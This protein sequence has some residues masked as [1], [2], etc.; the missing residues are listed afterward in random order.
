MHRRTRL[1][2]FGQNV[3]DA[4]VPK[5]Q[6]GHLPLKRFQTCRAQNGSPL[7]TSFKPDPIIVEIDAKFKM[8]CGFL[9]ARHNDFRAGRAPSAAAADVPPNAQPARRLCGLRFPAKWTR[10]D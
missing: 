3:K 9:G 2:A 5:Q 7:T 1:I 8:I 4:S 10:S 6:F